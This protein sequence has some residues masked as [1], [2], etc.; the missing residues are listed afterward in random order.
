MQ[1][2]WAEK[3]G[4]EENRRTDRGGRKYFQGQGSLHHLNLLEALNET[5]HVNHL[6]HLS[7]TQAAIVN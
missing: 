5:K 2:L 1:H 4:G 6:A 7:G 3:G